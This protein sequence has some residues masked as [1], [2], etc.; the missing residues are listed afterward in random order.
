[1]YSRS[2]SKNRQRLAYPRKWGALLRWLTVLLSAW[3]GPVQADEYQSVD[4]IYAAA[5]NFISEQLQNLPAS[6]ARPVQVQVGTLD[7]RLR[8]AACEIPLEAFLPAGGQSQ[9]NTTVGVRC[10][11]ARPWLLY[12]PVV[13]KAFSD[14]LVAT[15][16]LA[17][18]A[19]I[20]ASDLK[21][22]ALDMAN[23]PADYLS[24][25]QQVIGK[26]LKRPLSS[27]GVFGAS[28]LEAPRIVRR[29]QQVTLLAEDAGIEVRM[30]GQALS[31]GEQGQV[32]R[33]RN[34]LSKLVVEGIVTAPGVVKV[35]M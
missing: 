20:S 22:V 1:M 27:G 10:Q 4:S 23:L 26:T 12:V 6:A 31:D 13:V 15:H 3:H 34:T 8:L 32:I 28:L 2:Y 24:D 11:G 29:D 14:V 33:V 16:A 30:G 9:G 17:R 5:R 35:R 21:P 25:P 18:G 19:Q 7:P